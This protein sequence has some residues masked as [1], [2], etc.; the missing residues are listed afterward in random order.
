[1]NL[2]LRPMVHTDID[3]IMIIS[4]LSLPEPWSKKS[5]LNELSNPLARYIIAENSEG[6]IGYIGLW[7][8]L[9]EGHIT[10]IA[11]HPQ[12]REQGIGT[13]LIEALISRS[14]DWHITSITLEVRESNLIAQKL[15]NNFNFKVEGK[16]LNYYSDNNENALIMWKRKEAEY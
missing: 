16:R 4:S 11:V 13:K 2:T 6:I 9:D 10:N 5:M 15:Y 1:M 8:V 12:F 3:N 14:S 7:I